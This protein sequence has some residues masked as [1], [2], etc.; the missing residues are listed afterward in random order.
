M[1]TGTCNYLSKNE[2]YIIREEED[3]EGGKEL[4]PPSTCSQVKG[5]EISFDIIYRTVCLDLQSA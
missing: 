2:E 4:L 1:R 3:V 5:V